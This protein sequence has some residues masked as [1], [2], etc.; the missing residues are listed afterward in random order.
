[1]KFFRRLGGRIFITFALSLMLL[2]LFFGGLSA[3]FG[4]QMVIHSSSNE[5]RVVTVILSQLIQKQFSSLEANLE[6]V[7]ENSLVLSTIEYGERS[8]LEL[9]KYLQDQKTRLPFFED[10]I[11]YGM[12]G[13][14]V[15]ATDPDWYKI[16]GKGYRFFKEGQEDFGFPSI[17]GTDSAGKVQLVSAPI[18]NVRSHVV[19]VVVAIIRLNAVYELMDQKIGLSETTDAFLVDEDLR[20][21]TPGKV[22][23]SELVESHLVSTAL[24]EHVREEYW[25]G[26]YNNYH[27]E[28]VLGTALKIPGYSWYVVVERKYGDVVRRITAMQRVV[29]AVTLGLGLIFIITSL[30]LSRSITQPILQLVESARSMDEGNLHVPV[31]IPHQIEEVEFLGKEFERMRKR[32]AQ[33][34]DQL[35]ERLEVSE[36]LRIESERLAAI[37]TLAASLAHEIRNP[38]NAMNLLLSRLNTMPVAEQ[39]RSVIHDIFGEIGRLDRLVNSILDY[40]RPLQLE[41]ASVDLIQMIESI[42]V[43]YRPLL[44]ERNV[45]LILDFDTKSL[46]A[47]IDQD[48]IR[49]CLVNLIQNAL[50]AMPDGGR[51]TIAVKSFEEYARIEVDDSGT[52]IP[53]EIHRKL[54]SLFFTTKETGTGLGLS[55]VQKIVMAHGGSIDVISDPAKAERGEGPPGTRF[56]ITLPR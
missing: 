55:N 33:S 20:F 19:G 9:E 48:R 47:S 21:I 28:K 7:T 42:V 30:L 26:E 5:L 27:G 32:L 16:N 45:F 54:F 49:Q 15:G 50:D 14:C 4:R 23:P 10:I 53:V 43:L 17:Y 2:A 25:V 3:H 24:K 38:L 11:I 1:M 46:R 13:K 52:G 39:R 22:G 35:K 18:M 37:G 44:A 12:D 41:R 6:T 31:K 40:A 56:V 29:L 34:Q 8:R 36:A 51:L